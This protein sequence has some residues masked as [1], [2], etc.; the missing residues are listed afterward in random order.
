[1]AKDDAYREAERKI[2][3][4]RQSGSKELNLSS[5][6]LTELP[7]SLGQLKQL[8]TLDLSTNRLTALPESLPKLM[9]LRKLIA[10]SNEFTSLPESVSKLSLL[11]E[12]HLG[13]NPLSTLPEMLG[14][15]TQLRRLNVDYSKRLSS[16]PAALG[17]LTKLEHLDASVNQLTA[18]PESLGQLKQLQT[19]DLHRNRLTALPESLGQLKQLKE[20]DVTGNP[21]PK[22]ILKLADKGRLLAY[23]RDLAE[24]KARKGVAPAPFNEAKLLLVGPGEVGKSWLL[25]A[26]QGKVPQRV[27]STKGLEIA[28]EPLDMAHP[29]EA[30]RTIHFNCWDFGGQENYQIT[31]QIF[32]SPKGIYLL[33]WKPRKGMDPELLA[34][35][36]RIQLSAGRTA[37][38]FIVSTHADGNV[39]AVIGKEA[40]LERFGELIGGF[41]EVDS[42]KGPEGTGIAALKAAIAQAAA[43]LEGMDTPFPLTWHE[44]QKAVL[45]LRRQTIQLGKFRERCARHGLDGDAAES[46]AMIMDV[47]GQAVYFAEAARGA[48]VAQADNLIVLNPEWLAKAVT[49]VIEDR[50]TK[51]DFGVLLHQRLHEIW[52]KD[53]GTR[54]C[55]GYSPKLHRYL[56]WL[57]WKFDIAYRQNA[58]TSLVPELIGRNRPD[59]LRWTPSVRPQEPQIQLVCRIPQ[60]PPPGLIPVLTAAVHPLRRIQDP[61][62]I[63]DHLDRNWRD[64]FFLDTALRGTA[65]V[66]LND[67]D[68]VMVVRDKCPSDLARQLRKTLDAIVE[69]R[70]KQLK[71]DYCVPCP[72]NPALGKPCRGV[73]KLSYIEPRRG[74]KVPCQECGNDEVEVDNLLDGFDPNAEKIFRQLAELKAGQRELMTMALRIYRDTLDPARSE[75]ERAPCMF[76]ILPE[77]GKGWDAIR[78]LAETRMRVTC[79]CEHPDGPHPGAIIG[80]NEPP[81]YVLKAPKD[82]VIK[83]APYISWAAT[84]LK[85]FVPLAGTV[86][87]RGLGNALSEDLKNKIDLMSE[88]AKTLPS[89]KLDVDPRLDLE[90]TN[91]QRP[92]IVALR[93]IHD[94]LLKQVSEGQRWGD[95]RPVRT[96]SG[97]LLWLCAKHA[98]IQQP[99]V[100]K[101]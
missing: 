98:A 38:V 86:T 34:R 37:K 71:V 46:L 45:K 84:L 11:E 18:L 19:L 7:E 85:A 68:L 96:K 42:T 82:W 65:F 89:G 47:Q 3:E 97:D 73:F 36:E 22:E 52:K 4:A 75:F 69:M 70:W 30:G 60:T 10:Y 16:L 1:M 76:T 31:Q 49:L 35:L 72:G 8:Q 17:Q 12:L 93:H 79:W 90:F 63:Q 24:T 48:G 9:Q 77:E 21:L 66:E 83:A 64:G 50:K 67:R 74:W 33:V 39:P 53:G 81:D 23:L 32:F 40:I 56:L 43:Q 87:E 62:D 59:D 100:E 5:M 54:A 91:R 14:N 41:H 20:M 51:A 88:A 28:R 27:G 95:L 101:I 44:A 29:K 55:P 2:E 58:G 13:N 61:Q 57:M 15:L 26:L 92:E 6:G 94:A 99:P 80:S 78:D 25:Q